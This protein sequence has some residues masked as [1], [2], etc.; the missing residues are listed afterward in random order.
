MTSARTRAFAALVTVA[1]AMGGWAVAAPPAAPLSNPTSPQLTFSRTI[2]SHPFAGAPA[3]ASDIEGLGYVPA[4]NSMWVTDDNR[5]TVWEINPSTGAYKSQ[6]RGSASGST[7]FTAATQVGTGK[8]CGQALDATI[9]GDTADYEC[10]SRTDDFESVVYDPANDVLY[11]TSGDCCAA[12]LPLGYPN[13]PTV[14]KLGR[15]FGHFVPLAWQALPAG[16]DPTAAGWRPGVG[17]YFGHGSSI[18]TYNFAT[19]VLGAAFTPSGLASDVVGIAFT[20][21]STALVTTATSNTATGRTTATSDSTITKYT[22]SGVSTFT[23][24][25]GWSFPLKNVGVAG[26]NVDDDG[27]ID[28]RDLAVVGDTLYVP[29]GYDSRVSGDHPIYVYSLSGAVKPAPEF[30]W[31]GTPDAL[32]VQFTSTGT[33]KPVLTSPATTF[34]WNFGDGTA[35]SNLPNP[36]HKF[37]HSGTFTVQLAVFNAAGGTLVSHSVVVPSG[38]PFVSPGIAG[39]TEGNIGTT[40]VNVPV[41]LS[42]ASTTTVTVQYA[43][44]DTGAAGVATANVDYV[45][46]SGTVTFSPGQT[47][48]TVPITVKGD[49]IKE[50][51]LLY[52][53]WILVSFSN[54]VGAQLDTRFFGLGVGVIVDDD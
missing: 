22:V 35:Y 40:T 30:T 37:P 38:P 5:D 4:D 6:L 41:T 47:S 18:Q 11:V 32:T 33:P 54:P 34:V 7:D 42:Y 53:E 43:T 23:K 52:G 17:L 26:G 31:A 24:V 12:G 9:L 29:D 20:D 28:A 36:A 2:T 50:P 51:P 1:L 10:R 8:T 49:T 19:N 45:P 13:H 46:T 3:N 15:V 25:A 44:L 27:V 21:A 48:K 39:V 14:W 16:T